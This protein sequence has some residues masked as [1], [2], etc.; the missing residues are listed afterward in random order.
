MSAQKRTRNEYLN[1]AQT[2]LDDKYKHLQEDLVT[3]LENLEQAASNAKDDIWEIPTATDM[4]DAIKRMR[5]AIEM[6]EERIH[7]T[8]RKLTWLQQT[9]E[10]D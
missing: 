5:F 6:F 7:A 3:E 4:L 9:V 10:K 1:G 8:E 2:K